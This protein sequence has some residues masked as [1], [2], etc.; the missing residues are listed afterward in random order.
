MTRPIFILCLP[1][2]FSLSPV[3][4]SLADDL[5]PSAAAPDSE[6]ALTTPQV[7]ESIEQLRSPEF[8]VRQKSMETLQAVNAEQIDLLAQAIQT[9]PENEVARRCVDLLE[10]RYSSGDRDSAVVRQ[11]S[12][13]LEAAAKSDRWFVAEAARDSLE[14]HWKRRVEITMLELQKLGA[15]MSPK[16]PEKLWESNSEYSGPFKLQSPARDDHLKIFVDEHWKADAKGFELLRRLVPLVSHDFMTGQSRVSVVLIDGHTQQLEEVA[17]LKAIFG[18]TRVSL[19]GAV[20]LGIAH[21]P[22]DASR[23][24]VEVSEV[25]QD[26]SAFKAEIQADDILLKFND[27]PLKDFDELIELLKAFRPGDEVT[28]QV[29]RYG[30]RTPFDVKVK[31]QGWYE[32]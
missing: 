19:R 24:G 27:K 21:Q 6:P 9:S 23:I 10:R 13:A 30:D 12:D 5:A 4:M 31:L 14:R 15:G 11:A 20:C 16:A 18:D 26:S 8:A 3:G 32:R 29:R 1:L 22:Q 2:F 7:V 25:Q 17:E 28:F